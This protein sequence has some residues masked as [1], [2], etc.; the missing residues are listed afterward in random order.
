MSWV[1]VPTLVKRDSG[2]RPLA[3]VT[4]IFQMV[5][6]SD[7]EKLR[8]S[9]RK[10][11]DPELLRFGMVSKYKCSLET[12]LDRRPQESFVMHLKEAREEWKRRY[13]KLPLNDSF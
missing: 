3:S 5:E 9:L 8:Q 4:A 10:M 13:P 7:I 6:K 12:N 2:D 1:L 11:S